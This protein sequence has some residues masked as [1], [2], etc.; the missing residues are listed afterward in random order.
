M[1]LIHPNKG[2]F[3]DLGLSHR[4]S[5]LYCPRSSGSWEN[6]GVKNGVSPGDI[7]TGKV[8]WNFEN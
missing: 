3:R 1:P 8:T 2:R 4:F 7:H 6:P 5:G